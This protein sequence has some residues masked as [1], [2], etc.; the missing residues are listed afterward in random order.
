MESFFYLKHVFRATSLAT[1]LFFFSISN[2]SAEIG[3]GAGIPLGIGQLYPSVELNVHHDDN[4]LSAAT[5]EVDTFVSILS[6]QLSYQIESNKSL[7]LMEYVLDVGEHYSSHNDDYTDHNLRAEYEYQ[8]TSRIFTALRGQY[9]DTRDPRG[10]GA[11]EGGLTSATDPDE[12]NTLAIL[13]EAGYGS[14]EAKGR[15]EFDIGFMGK[16]YTNNR[17]TTFVRDRD[18]FHGSARAFYRFMTRTNF[19]LEGRARNFNYEQDATGTAGLDSTTMKY[20]AGVTWDA[21]Y[22][23]TG[24]AKIGVID[25][26]FDS[27]ARADDDAL[28]WEVGV[29]W[30]PRTYSTFTLS[31][32][33]DFTETNGTGDFVEESSVNVGWQHAWRERLSSSVNFTFAMDDYTTTREDDRINASATVNY[34]LRRWLN[35]GA[36][37]TYDERD[38]NTNAFDY[39]RN[40]FELTAIITL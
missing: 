9:V 19:V 38:S 1:A 18:E 24:F 3:D 39:D 31:T 22:K 6:P 13:G 4:L 21:T 8:P 25:K 34:E 7:I 5:G 20:L 28:L 23:T 33:R 36:G 11:S 35:L 2:S 15:V 26:D 12:Y 29:E 27:S 17:A 32:Q 37:Y 14:E 10:T 30:Q 40:K 16:D